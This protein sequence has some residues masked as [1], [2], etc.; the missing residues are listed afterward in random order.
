LTPEGRGRAR[1]PRR[2]R[3]KLDEEAVVAGRRG[4]KS[5][6]DLAREHGVSVHPIVRVLR[7]HGIDTGR[8]PDWRLTEERA[9]EAL[10]RWEAERGSQPSVRAWTAARATPSTTTLI[11]LFGSWA[12]ALVAAGMEALPPGDWRSDAEIDEFD[13]ESAALQARVDAGET[14][15]G[16]AP[17]L[18]V[19]P[20]SLG[21]RL[22]AWRELYGGEHRAPAAGRPPGRSRVRLR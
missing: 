16:I 17:E 20:Q 11:E 19:A 14:L 9:V 22:R 3:A 15:S 7:E 13:R 2:K 10:R 1:R 12:N 5:L 8:D 18:G 6:R 21:R 4:G